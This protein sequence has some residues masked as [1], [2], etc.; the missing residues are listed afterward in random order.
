MRIL[1]NILLYTLISFIVLLFS[2]M[3]K[4]DFLYSFLKKDLMN[5]LIGLLGLNI[6]ILSILVSKLSEI[7]KN[8]KSLNIQDI[9]REMKFSLIEFFVV[10]I[11]AVSSSIIGDSQ[12]V[13][14]FSKNLVINSILLSTLIYALVIIW[15][16]GHSIFVLIDEEESN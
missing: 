16:T 13:Q 3:L 9:T 7:K 14:F 8:I 6:A 10:I 2:N 1:K 11:L 15:D 5:I 4:S 12:Q